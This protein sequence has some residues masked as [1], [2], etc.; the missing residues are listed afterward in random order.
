MVSKIEKHI[1]VLLEVSQ[2]FLQYS[3]YLVYDVAVCTHLDFTVRSDV[4]HIIFMY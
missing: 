4:S 2:Q 3:V 1:P